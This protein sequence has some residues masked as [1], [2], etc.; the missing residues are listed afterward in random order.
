MKKPGKVK[1]ALLNWLGVP[2]GLTDGKFWAAWAS[3][4]AAGQNINENS[5]MSLS[6][7]WAC[8]KLISE[9]IGT[10]PV[11]IYERTPDGRRIAK[12][13]PLYNVIHN[14]P[15]QDTIASTFWESNVATILLRGNGLN[16][17]KR[18]G[19]RVLALEFLPY[20]RLSITEVRGEYKIAYLNGDGTRT[21]IPKE[22]IFHIPGF[23]LNGKWG[24][25]AI[26]YG[27]SVFGSGLAA[28]SAAN[29]TFER[30]LSPTTAFSMEKILKKEQ[31]EEFRENIRNISGAIN[32]G[33]AALLEGGMTATQIGINPRDAQLLESR[34]FS[35]E[36]VCSWFGVD[37]SMI[38]KGTSA[39]NW[40][41]GLE[42]KMIYFLT[43]TLRPFLRRIEQAIN[44]NLLTPAEQQKYYA[45]FNIEGLLRADS[46]SRAEF[47]RVMINSG[48]QTID[49]VRAKENLPSKGGNADKLMVHSAMMPIDDLGKGSD[50]SSEQVRNALK[51]WL[52]EKGDEDEP[53]R[54]HE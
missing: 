50:N 25:S 43:F 27:A 12:E 1:S 15:N 4:N 3:E 37:P 54:N 32:S 8:V 42:Q 41:T 52:T 22:D 11:H 10:L 44:T 34:R 46:R 9:A 40:G 49:E 38:G 13:H 45:E 48:I 35:A 5:V 36:E 18:L 30:G 16:R 53:E 29:K 24:V 20:D 2:I 51:S 21:N 23:S 28:N 47:Y 33:E 31:R 14:R 39:S 7:A 19:G 6:A 26:Q 17:M